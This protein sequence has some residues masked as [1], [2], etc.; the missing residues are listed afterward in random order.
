MKNVLQ[1]SFIILFLSL[2]N[3]SFAQRDTLALNDNWQFTTDKSA[4]GLKDNWQT[5]LLPNAR[6]VVLPHTWNIEE[7]N[8]NHYGWGWYQKKLIVPANWKNKNV[9]LQFGA[10]NHT[11]IIYLNGEKVAEHKGDGFNKFYVN[12]TGKLNFGKENVISVACNNDY[13]KEKVP[14]GSSFDWPNDGGIIRKVALM[15]SDKPAA[16]YLHAAPV[17]NVKNNSGKLKLK[18]GYDTENTN[19]KFVVRI[20]EENQTT[21]NIICNLF[22]IVSDKIPGM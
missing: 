9:V 3:I 19:L 22:P 18:L 6:T 11:S 8:Q 14:F 17:L 12:L 5:T 2:A 20:T 4:V 7:A 13:G 10:I 15:I 1:Y 21:Q 16:N